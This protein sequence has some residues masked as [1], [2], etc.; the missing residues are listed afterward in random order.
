MNTSPF[1]GIGVGK[2]KEA[3]ADA[4]IREIEAETAAKMKL[5][6]QERKNLLLQLEAAKQGFEP[7]KDKQTAE[8]AKANAE[9]APEKTLYTV[10][11]VIVAVVMAGLYFIKK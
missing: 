9:A 4:R 5:A 3:E 1:L 8:I 6:E 11:G 2:K 10:V 7:E